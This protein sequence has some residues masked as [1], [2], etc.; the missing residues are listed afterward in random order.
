MIAALPAR[1]PDQ[2][3]DD[4]GVAPEVVV[5]VDCGPWHVEGNV[6]GEDVAARFRLEPHRRLLLV[7][8]DLPYK[9]KQRNQ[10]QKEIN[11][12]GPKGAPISTIW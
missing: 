8:P 5:E 11:Y 7:D 6:V 12:T 3:A 9:V 1:V 4:R 2:I 10:P